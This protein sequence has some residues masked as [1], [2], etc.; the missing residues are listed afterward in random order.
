M[1]FNPVIF[2]NKSLKMP[3]KTKMPFDN[4]I[5]ASKALSTNDMWSKTIGHDPYAS[6]NDSTLRNQEA[7]LAEQSESLLQLAKMTKLSGDDSRSMN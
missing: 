2:L 7:M 4:R 5:S 1:Q 3:V 6:S